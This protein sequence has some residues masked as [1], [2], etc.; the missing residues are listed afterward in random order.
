MKRICGLFG[1]PH[2]TR[3]GN[4]TGNPFPRSGSCMPVDLETFR[5]RKIPLMPGFDR[6]LYRW[7]RDYFREQFVMGVCG[8]ALDEKTEKTLERELSL[9]AGRI[10]GEGR[11]LIHRDLQSQNILIRENRPAFIDFQ[12]MRQGSLFYDLASLLYDPYVRFREEER[13]DLLRHY[14]QDSGS[15]PE[16]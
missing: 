5:A 10:E 11:H 2:G 15:E 14:H 6:A 16:L 12:G 8:I 1:K 3:A 7:E 4:S 13:M 9:L